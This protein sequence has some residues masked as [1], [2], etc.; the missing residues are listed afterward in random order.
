MFVVV[1][2]M[3]LDLCG[4]VFGFWFWLDVWILWCLVLLRGCLFG[5]LVVGYYDVVILLFGLCWGV[6][7]DCVVVGWLYCDRLG[8]L[9]L[10][11]V[12]WYLVNLLWLL[13]SLG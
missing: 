7:H 12:C 1:G 13:R 9:D 10:L 8:L 3:F 2:V 4:C 11:L 5:W 6:F